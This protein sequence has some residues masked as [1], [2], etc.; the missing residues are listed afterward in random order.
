MSGHVDHGQG[1]PVFLDGAK[2]V[3]P[4]GGASAIA[5]SESTLPPGVRE[6]FRKSVTDILRGQLQPS[7]IDVERAIVVSL[8]RLRRKGIAA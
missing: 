1:P 2:V 4:T 5:E 3:L 6:R 8:E 7:L